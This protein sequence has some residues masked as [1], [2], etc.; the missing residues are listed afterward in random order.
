MTKKQYPGSAARTRVENS[1]Y[2]GGNA[3]MYK[4]YKAKGGRKKG[5]KESFN[6]LNLSSFYEHRDTGE[7]DFVDLGSVTTSKDVLSGIISG[8]KKPRS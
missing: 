4:P 5:E 2:D 6:P 7:A 3:R 1:G 8:R